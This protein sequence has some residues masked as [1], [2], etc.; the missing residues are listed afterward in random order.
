MGVLRMTASYLLIVSLSKLLPIP[1]R[2]PCIPPTTDAAN[3]HW[4]SGFPL[5]PSKR[6]R[7]LVSVNSSAAQYLVWCK[8]WLM[9]DRI[10]KSPFLLHSSVPLSYIPILQ[11][12][13]P[14]WK[15]SSPVQKQSIA[16]DSQPCRPNL[17]Y[18][19]KAITTDT[20][21]I[22]D[23]LAVQSSGVRV[24]RGNSVPDEERGPK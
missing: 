11:H 6:F 10:M 9:L 4:N 7:L 5:R 2:F 16:D 1:E 23:W 22:H 18:V 15:H 12:A 19:I 20:A 21:F 17:L 14:I 8:V 3:T 24:R 13:C